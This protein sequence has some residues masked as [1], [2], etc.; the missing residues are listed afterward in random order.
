MR[1]IVNPGMWHAEEKRLRD[2]M[3]VNDYYT[4]SANVFHVY[5]YAQKVAEQNALLIEILVE[6]G[7]LTLEDCRQFDAP[8]MEKAP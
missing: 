1:V 2:V 6:K 3:L 8:S 4:D 7:F 5:Q